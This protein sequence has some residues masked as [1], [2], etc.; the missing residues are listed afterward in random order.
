MIGPNGK[1]SVVVEVHCNDFGEADLLTCFG[2]DAR[3]ICYEPQFYTKTGRHFGEIYN[4]IEALKEG[5]K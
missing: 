3:T 5:E 4:V 2:E 1:K